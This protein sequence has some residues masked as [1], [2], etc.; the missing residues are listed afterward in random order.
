[1]QGQCNEGVYEHWMDMVQFRTIGIAIGKIA[2]KYLGKDGRPNV[3]LGNNNIPAMP[4]RASAFFDQKMFFW[5]GRF[6]TRT[7]VIKMHAN[8]LGGVH[9]DLKRADDEQQIREIKNYFGFEIQGT[10]NQMLIGNDISV[11]RADPTRRQQVYDATELV[12]MDTARIFAEGVR[13]S[14][15]EFAGLIA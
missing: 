12:A 8:A 5:K 11:A 15:R 7:D 4:Q 9:F 14:A 13:A 10:N 1:M 2:E 6:Y 3:P